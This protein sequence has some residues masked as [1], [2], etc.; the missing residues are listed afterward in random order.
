MC[1]TLGMCHAED[2]LFGGC[3]VLRVLSVCYIGDVPC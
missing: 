3:F 1:V 2:V